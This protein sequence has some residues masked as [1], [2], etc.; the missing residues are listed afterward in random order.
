MFIER[1]IAPRLKKLS[2]QF[3]VLGILG[4]RQS[5]KTTIAKALFPSYKYINLE[6]LDTRRFAQEDPKR[7]LKAL[8]AEQGAIL[9]EIQRVPDL[10]SYIQVHVDQWQKPGFFILTGS[11][12]ILHNHHIS[13]TLAGRIALI[14]LLPLSLDELEKASLLPTELEKVLFQGFYPSI[15]AKRIDPKEWIQSYIQ[16]YIERDVRHLKQ[17]TDLS[18]FQKFLHLCAGRVGQLLDLTSI[19]NDCGITAHTVRSWLSILE[20]TYVIFLLQPYYKNFNKRVIKAPKLYFYDSAVACNLLSIQ[21]PND[22]L[23]HYL[24]GGLFESM[25]LADL[26]KQRC[27]IG[28]SSNLYFWRDKS[29]YEV[30]CI[31]EQANQLVPIEIKSSETINTD[32][33][34]NLTKWNDL[35]G[36]E[37]SNGYVVYGG[38]EKQVRNKGTILS[39]RHLQSLPN[40]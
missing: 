13:Q 35:V 1:K 14:T 15:Y 31:L 25:I 32:F 18:L 38:P 11:E 30:D 5:G 16:T 39:W 34:S 29:G 3:P 6:E 36:S 19:G 21:S 4:P 40:V 12:N 26:I 10:L 23:T 37:I 17:I 9:D 20:A 28:L 2:A 22:L 33:F 7:F 27:N 24:R 8:E